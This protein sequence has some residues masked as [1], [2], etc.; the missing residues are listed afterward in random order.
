MLNAPGP[1]TASSRITT[2]DG[3]VFHEHQRVHAFSKVAV[4]QER[5]QQG[6]A[7]GE[8]RGSAGQETEQNCQTA[9]ELKQNSQRQQRTQGRPW[10]PYTAAY[11]H[12][13]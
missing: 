6:K 2:S 8:Q 10:L 12:T 1:V 3:Q 11:P 9:A 4:E 5:G 13:R 7:C